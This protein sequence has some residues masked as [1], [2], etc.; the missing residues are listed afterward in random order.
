MF[1]IVCTNNDEVDE[2]TDSTTYQIKIFIDFPSSRTSIYACHKLKKKKLCFWQHVKKFFINF[3]L[4]FCYC[5]K[6]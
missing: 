3:N 1:S 2:L 6:Y 4:H 5:M